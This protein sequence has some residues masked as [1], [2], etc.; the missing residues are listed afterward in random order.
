M[1]ALKRNCAQISSVE[2]LFFIYFLFFPYFCNTELFAGVCI[3]A[4]TGTFIG[5]AAEG[6]CPFFF[7]ELVFFAHAAR[8]HLLFDRVMQIDCPEKVDGL[9]ILILSDPICILE[10][11]E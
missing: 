9:A 8:I 6:D 7:F 2:S 10:T 11:Q 5:A 4:L 1:F 3:E